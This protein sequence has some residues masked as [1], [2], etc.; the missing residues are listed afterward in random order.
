[1]PSLSRLQ[2]IVMPTMAMEMATT[3]MVMAM[4]MEMATT[5]ITTTAKKI[6][7]CYHQSLMERNEQ[8]A[9]Q[10]EL[11]TPKLLHVQM[12]A[13]RGSPKR[14]KRRRDAM[15]TVVANVKP[16]ANIERPTVMDT[17]PSAMILGLLGEMV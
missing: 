5:T 10:M 3:T 6:M 11:V 17:A 13:H 8:N 9:K 7:T 1:M 14:T 15:L 16:L 4:A 2:A 12:N